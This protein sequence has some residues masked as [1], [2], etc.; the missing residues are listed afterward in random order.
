M[1]VELG[2]FVLDAGSKCLTRPTAFLG[3]QIPARPCPELANGKYKMMCFNRLQL[4]AVMGRTIPLLTFFSVAMCR[5]L[6]FKI[7]PS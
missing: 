3:M 4:Q 7:H 5:S 6:A 1:V 2:Y